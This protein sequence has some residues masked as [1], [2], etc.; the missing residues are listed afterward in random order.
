MVTGGVAAI[1]YGEPRLTNDVDV[2]V[3]GAPKYATAF[4]DAFST[5]AYYVPPP[6][7]LVAELGRSRH[8]HFNIIHN[9]TGLRADVYVAGD[10]VLDAWAMERRHTEL[11]GADSIWFAPIEYVI[12]RKLEYYSHGGSERHLR[13]IS[14]MLRI[15]GDTI[16]RSALDHLIRD[17][18]LHFSWEKARSH[19]E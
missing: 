7:V 14:A 17:R 5:A 11:L 19:P 1:A 4:T 6:E 9:D 2:V 18:Q 12:V 15:S 16:D 3:D 10:D 8:G 13:D